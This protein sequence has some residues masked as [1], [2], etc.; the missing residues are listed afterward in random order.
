MFTSTLKIFAKAFLVLAMIGGVS[1]SGFM[2]NDAQAAMTKKGK[3]S[4]G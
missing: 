3:N 4:G 2:I 1:V